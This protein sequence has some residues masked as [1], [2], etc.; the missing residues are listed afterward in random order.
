VAP[1]ALMGTG[2]VLVTHAHLR[3]LTEQSPPGDGAA[4]RPHRARSL[5]GLLAAPGG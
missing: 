4:H 5:A 2:A 1:V 3:T